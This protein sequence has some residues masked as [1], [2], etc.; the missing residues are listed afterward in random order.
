LS[1][2]RCTAKSKQ[3][4]TRCKRS[5]IPGGAVCALHG[6][7]APQ[8]VRTA[9]AR[10]AAL[11]DPALATLGVL[12]KRPTLAHVRL[13]AARDVLDRAGIGKPPRLGLEVSGTVHLAGLRARLD[14]MG[15]EDAARLTELLQRDPASLTAEEQDELDILRR[16]AGL[17]TEDP[18]A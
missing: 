3:S 7:K 8:V 9:R 5:P 16:A 17:A 12:M 13:G 11:V 18:H 4:G 6:G 2:R 10:L 15:E 1:G 14:A